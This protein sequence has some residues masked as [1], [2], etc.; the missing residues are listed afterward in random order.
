MLWGVMSVV[1]CDGFGAVLCVCKLNRIKKA[2]LKKNSG[3][4]CL[5]FTE[6][7]RSI[8]VT[9]TDVFAYGLTVIKS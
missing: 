2:P 8:G 5:P 4:L 7:I 3:V 1:G 9:C 6:Q